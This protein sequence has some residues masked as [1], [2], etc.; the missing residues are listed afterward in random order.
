[1]L[2]NF[3]P[4]QFTAPSFLLTQDIPLMIS[5]IHVSPHSLLLLASAQKDPFPVQ[6]SQ[7]NRN[8]RNSFLPR[9][10]GSASCLW[11][12]FSMPLLFTYSSLTATVSVKILLLTCSLGKLIYCSLCTLIVANHRNFGI[13]FPYLPSPLHLLFN[14]VSESALA[15]L[16][17]IQPQRVSM[18]FQTHTFLQQ[19]M[20]FK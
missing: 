2:V 14:N 11:Y 8:N 4:S 10:L 9:F 19:C 5:T 15:V 12:Q 13:P 1:M 20:N 16:H 6:C 18:K 7:S 3:S 17:E